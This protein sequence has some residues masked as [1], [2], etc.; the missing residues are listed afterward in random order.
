MVKWNETDFPKYTVVVTRNGMTFHPSSTCSFDFE[1]FSQQRTCTRE[2]CCPENKCACNNDK[3]IVNL[4]LW[5][6]HVNTR[7]ETWSSL[8]QTWVFSSSR[9]VQETRGKAASFNHECY[10][11]VQHKRSLVVSSVLWTT[12]ISWIVIQ[13]KPHDL[14]LKSPQDIAKC[15]K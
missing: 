3:P 2:S 12:T 8:T 7:L 1:V 14:H 4:S 9:D 11:W 13:L 5:C 10:E 6:D 15:C